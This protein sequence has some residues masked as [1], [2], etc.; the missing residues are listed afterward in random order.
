MK[1][2]KTVRDPCAVCYVRDIGFIH[3]KQMNIHSHRAIYM[4]NI[5]IMDVAIACDVYF[6]TYATDMAKGLQLTI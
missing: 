4:A 6:Q 2:Y 5:F 3:S 1:N